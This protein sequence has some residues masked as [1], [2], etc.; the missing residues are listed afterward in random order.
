MS[1]STSYII[2]WAVWQCQILLHKNSFLRKSSILTGRILFFF[3]YKPNAKAHEIRLTS[4]QF[5]EKVKDTF[6]SRCFTLRWEVQCSSEGKSPRPTN[7]A[8]DTGHYHKTITLAF[9]A[10]YQLSAQCQCISAFC[11]AVNKTWKP[12]RR[13][14]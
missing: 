7:R 2:V 10:G 14:N 12:K 13:I 1:Y 11:F 8:T 5:K 4:R 3:Y 6:K 9:G